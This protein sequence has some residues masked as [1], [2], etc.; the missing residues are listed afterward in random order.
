MPPDDLIR[1]LKDSTGLSVIWRFKTKTGAISPLADR[2]TF[3]STFL[4]GASLERDSLTG[5]LIIDRATGEVRLPYSLPDLHNIPR[6][7]GRYVLIGYQPGESRPWAGGTCRVE[8][9]A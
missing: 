4:L 1:M 9:Y 7:D 5:G 6:C 2:F 8:G 3:R